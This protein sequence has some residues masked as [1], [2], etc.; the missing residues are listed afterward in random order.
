MLFPYK[1]IDSR[2]SNRTE[3]DLT[4]GYQPTHALFYLKKGS[5]TIETD[6][7]KEEIVENDCILLPSYIY[8]RRSVSN[9]IEFIYV[10]FAGNPSCPYSFPIP[11][12][13][14]VPKNKERFISNI[15]SIEKCIEKADAL[16]ASYCEHLLLDI[17]FEAYYE[18]EPQNAS[19]D[20][21][22]FDDE[23]VKTAVQ[24]ILTNID[25]KLTIDEIC[26]EA[27]TNPSTLNF[28]FRREFGISTGQFILTERLKLAKRLLNRTTYSISN[29]AAKC[30]FENVYY[31][32]NF[33]KKQT[34]IMPSKYRII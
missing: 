28:K 30:G 16:S 12:G 20:D 8:F 24:Y 3:F 6:G 15:C 32:S 1:I 11:F 5:F 18:N 4:E 22:V 7:K 34:G 17:L 26:R 31:F 29:I 10:K 9:P 14:I 19:P 13:K 27:G 25:K 21:C 33:F 23:I 2:I